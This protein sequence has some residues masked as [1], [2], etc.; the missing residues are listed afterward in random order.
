M[1][2]FLLLFI[3]IVSIFTSNAQEVSKKHKL[4]IS[5]SVSF[6]GTGDILLSGLSGQYNHSITANFSLLSRAMMA[7]GT[8]TESSG[9]FTSNQIKSL[10]IGLDFKSKASSF[11]WIG[12]ELGL[13]ILSSMLIEGNAYTKIIDDQNSRPYGGGFGNTTIFK[14]QSVGFFTGLNFR[15]IQKEHFQSGLSLRMQRHINGDVINTLGLFCGARF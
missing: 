5:P 4:R 10:E 14:D 8:Q 11:N 3:L 12:L 9:D 15:L 7:Q 13:S 6:N 2:T 1:K